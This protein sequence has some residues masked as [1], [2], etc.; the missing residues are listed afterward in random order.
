[1]RSF[2]TAPHQLLTPET[3]TELNATI[4]AMSMVL[5]DMDTV[6]DLLEEAQSDSEEDEEAKRPLL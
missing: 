6:S 5:L 2:T 4:L 3:V 1:M